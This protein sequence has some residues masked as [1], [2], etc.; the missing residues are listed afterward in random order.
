MFLILFQVPHLTRDQHHFASLAFNCS[1]SVMARVPQALKITK[2][3]QENHNFRIQSL[4]N[5]S[6]P[7]LQAPNLVFHIRFFRF[8]TITTVTS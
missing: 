8:R 6:L 2:N 3:I 5:E 7:T 4:H 1:D